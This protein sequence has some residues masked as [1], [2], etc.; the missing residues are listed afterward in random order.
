MED[1]FAVHLYCPDGVLGAPS[2]A[3]DEIIG[4]MPRRKAS[5]SLTIDQP[6]PISV[7]PAPIPVF[8]TKIGKRKPSVTSAGSN[9][10]TYVTATVGVN[11][12]EYD[13]E[14]LR[15]QKPGQ[16]HGFWSLENAEYY[17][18]IKKAR[19]DLAADH[20][21]AF[22]FE[23]TY[24]TSSDV[25]ILYA[26]SFFDFRKVALPF[27]SRRQDKI[28][29]AFISNC[30]PMNNRTKILQ[31]LMDLLPGQIDSFGRCLNNTRS[32]QVIQELNLNPVIPGQ[33][34]PNLSLWE[35]KIRIIGRYKFTI[36]F[37]NANEEDY[38]TEKYYQAL[39]EGS[40]PIHLGLTTDQFQKFKPSPNSALN[41]ADFDTIEEL[42]NRIKQLS[43]DRT[44]Y[45]SMLNW[46]N[47][48]FPQQFDEILGWGKVSEACRIAKFDLKKKFRS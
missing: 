36:A 35:E 47:Q 37:E 2:E 44:S 45:E 3:G 13:G 20:P 10:S 7:T 46:K 5:E 11:I 42:A 30:S 27:E 17:P 33:E 48:T 34:H 40:I 31:N 18:E 15:R 24:K 39:S 22:D 23:V 12:S 41:V 26:Y 32:D 28:A 6:A 25:P 4:N 38:V 43:N 9:T 19:E 21:R 8:L 29:A 1:P 16:L 14:T